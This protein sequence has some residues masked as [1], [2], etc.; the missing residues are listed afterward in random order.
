MIRTTKI[1]N[2]RFRNIGKRTKVWR[3]LVDLFFYKFISKSDTVLD[4]GGGYCE[5]INSIKCKKKYVLDINSD[6]KKYA[7][8][9]VVVLIASS[10]KIPLAHEK[11]DKIFISNFFEHITREDIIKTIIEMRR[12]LKKNGEII[13]MHPNIRFLQKDF[14]RFFDHITP[15][16]DRALEEIFSV[17]DFSVEKKILRFLPYTM[18]GGKNTPLTFVKIY[19]RFSILWKFFGKQSLLV[20]KKM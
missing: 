16:D 18:S 4:I 6:V 3:I 12:V 5:F 8:K 1:Y 13:T 19:L 7:N 20:F 9:D 10:T 15:I 11:I 17:Y 2:K 14:W